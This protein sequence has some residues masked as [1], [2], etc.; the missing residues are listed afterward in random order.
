MVYHRFFSHLQAKL[1]LSVNTVKPV[2]TTTCIKRAPVNYGRQVAVPLK[3]ALYYVIT[4][5]V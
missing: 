2:L 1:G 3:L 4:K 5:P